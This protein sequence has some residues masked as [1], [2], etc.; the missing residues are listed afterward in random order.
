MLPDPRDSRLS[1]GRAANRSGGNDFLAQIRPLGRDFCRVKGARSQV[2]LCGTPRRSTSV[3]VND[4]V[5]RGRAVLRVVLRGMVAGR[6]LARRWPRTNVPQ[7]GVRR[8]WRP[9]C[10]KRSWRKCVQEPILTSYPRLTVMRTSI[11]AGRA[12]RK[13]SG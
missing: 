8:V 5:N 3:Q 4:Y 7:I 12:D 10:G 1:P 11:C 9:H 13:T 2:H 6:L